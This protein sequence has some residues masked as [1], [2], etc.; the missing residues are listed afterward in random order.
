[1]ATNPETE[2]FD[3]D[4]LGIKQIFGMM[5]NDTQVITGEGLDGVRL[6]PR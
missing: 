2:E 5:P 3:V 1:M 4:M 6:D